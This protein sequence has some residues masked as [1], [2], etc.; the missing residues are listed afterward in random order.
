MLDK[1][2]QDEKGQLEHKVTALF[3]LLSEIYGTEKLLLKAGKLDILDIL[4]SEDIK[5]QLVALQKIILDHPMLDKV[6]DEFEDKLKLLK[7]LE[8]ILVD[9][10]AKKSIKEELEE[11]INKKLELR[12]QEYIKEI[13]EEIINE[14]SKDDGAD[15]PATL[16]KYIELEYLENK[17]L[18][19][20]AN[21]LL[22]PKAL[23]EIVGQ[24]RGI[25]ALLAKLSSPYPQHIII[26]GPPG[27]GKT[28][29]ARLALE[30]AKER[31]STP[32]GDD[33]KFIEVDATT[34][35][36]DPREVT[37]PLLGSVHDPIYQGA[38]G[39]LA[40]EG[41]PEPKLGLVTK[42]HG[43]VLFIDE[44]GELDPILQNKLLKVLE[45]KRVH[46][47][48]SYYDPDDEN[49]PQY[50]KKLFKDG[51]PADFILVGATTRSPQD[52]NPA[53]RSRTTSIF[54]EP[55]TKDDIIKIIKQAADKLDMKVAK[56][57]AQLISEYTIQGRSAVNILIDAYNLA[58]YY[59]KNKITT[60]EVLEAVKLSR[61]VP[62]NRKEAS[63]KS[64]VGRVLGLGVSGFL[65]SVLEVEAIA[66]PASKEGKGSLRF[67]Q[68]A[69]SMTKDSIFTAASVI[70]KVTGKEISDYDIHVNII[71]GGQVDGPSAGSAISVAIISALEEIAVRQDIAITGEISLHG[72][73]KPVG[74]V[75]EKIYGA[76]QAGVEEVLIPV[77]NK[78]DLEDMKIKVSPVVDIQEVLDKMLDG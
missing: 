17:G 11:K 3:D 78:V 72:K 73:V 71:G 63:N 57:V 27:V 77:D 26:H 55:L 13:K 2:T 49:V 14:E 42:A 65:G 24:E 61:L 48:S 22:R 29:A 68:T 75:I 21:N 31:E 56:G 52:L 6:P 10:L 33:A 41:I 19:V 62:I 16:K 45:D 66:F 74:G 35:R 76:Y 59:Q 51:A 69:G 64:Q 5:D 60:K 12:H 9:D 20:S 39:K 1:R 53:L 47:D 8:D 70:R 40:Q 58:L 32:F 18:N 46:F 23:K 4:E 54:F 34:L 44:I 38:K 7:E 15:T 36:W 30:I 37:N 50:I 28:T 43:G 25:K 67:N